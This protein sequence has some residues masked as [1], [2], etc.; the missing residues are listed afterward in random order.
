MAKKRSNPFENVKLAN[1]KSS[2]SNVSELGGYVIDF[3]DKLEGGYPIDFSYLSTRPQ[4]ARNLLRAL[5]KLVDDDINIINIRSIGSF[6]NGL[7]AF[8][9]YMKHKEIR[10][11]DTKELTTE[12]MTDYRTW[13]Y[14]LPVS[15]CSPSYA[16]RN[17]QSISRLVRYLRDSLDDSLN[18]L[19]S[20]DI[21]VPTKGLLPLSYGSVPTEP[22][23]RSEML[24]VERACRNAV[25]EVRGRIKLGHSLADRGE[26][27]RLTCGKKGCNAP[28]WRVRENI[29]WYVKNIAGV[30][31][32]T[33]DDLRPGHGQFLNA[34]SIIKKK[35]KKHAHLIGVRPYSRSDANSM[36]VPSTKDLLPFLILMLIKSGL[37]LESVLSLLWAQPQSLVLSELG[38]L[39]VAVVMRK[40]NALSLTKVNFLLSS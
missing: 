25:T 15:G 7:N 22:Y 4:L 30:D 19:V 27:P 13:L 20:S 10:V 8:W 38:T 36:L 23:T 9:R 24:T 6:R 26:D 28:S 39:R 5:E 40:W 29:L 37:N 34:T 14:D 3:T 31:W 35:T 16:R 2:A 12:I 21:E 11:T 17:W 33:K 1:K 18:S 32:R